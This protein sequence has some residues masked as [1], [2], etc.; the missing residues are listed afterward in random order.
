MPF[1][2]L[3]CPVDCID[4]SVTL[5]NMPCLGAGNALCSSSLPS[6]LHE[7]FS[8]IEQHASLGRFRSLL[9]CLINTLNVHHLSSL[10]SCS[11]TD[12]LQSQF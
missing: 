4:G 3:H 7:W 5:S 2:L 9:S 11:L 12:A 1:A 10:D 8:Q 6:G